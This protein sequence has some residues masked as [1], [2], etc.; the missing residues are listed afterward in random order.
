MDTILCK[1][2]KP[3]QVEFQRER[4][5]KLGQTAPIQPAENDWLF[6]QLADSAF[7]MGGFAHSGGLEAAFQ[8]GELGTAQ[9]LRAFIEASLCQFGHG[10]LPFMSSAHRSPEKFCALD[11]LCDNFI[12]NHVAN[13]ASRVQGQAML[14]SAERIFGSPEL[15]KLRRLCLENSACCHLAPTFGVIMRRLSFGHEAASRLFVYIHLR[16]LLS[17]A[18]RL[19]VVG[20][21][22][23]Q[24]LQHGLSATA[25]EVAIRCH[26][27]LVDD[28]S[29]TAPLLDLWQ[30]N[31]DRLYS[32]LFQS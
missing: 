7:P 24:M 12:S 25:E 20:P 26:N 27:L 22:Q 17:A 13:C 23:G 14:A 31:Q 16:G 21:L 9:D 19:G 5:G 11:G 1:S 15:Q 3:D 2:R 28:I 8:Q 32:R 6:W 30:G 29:Q 18:V 10:S 4:N